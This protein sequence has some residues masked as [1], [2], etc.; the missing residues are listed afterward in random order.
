MDIFAIRYRTPR[1]AFIIIKGKGWCVDA[2]GCGVVWGRDGMRTRWDAL[3]ACTIPSIVAQTYLHTGSMSK[4]RR[5]SV[6]R[7]SSSSVP[8]RRRPSVVFVVR[9]RASVVVVV[10]RRTSV[11]VSRRRPSSSVVVVCPSV[12]DRAQ[13]LRV[14]LRDCSRTNAR[15]RRDVYPNATS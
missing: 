7:P 1:L 5:P 3:L 4:S 13:R 6:V 15:T 10:Q 14:C 12:V 2:M 8:V 9:R 11:V